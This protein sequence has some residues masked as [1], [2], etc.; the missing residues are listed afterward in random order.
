MNAS[1][2]VQAALSKE[3]LKQLISAKDASVT[4]SKQNEKDHTSKVWS[5]FSTIFVNNIK[6][7]YVLCESCMLL[8]AYKHATGTGGMQKHIGSCSQKSSSMDELNKK[9][10]R[11][12]STQ[13]KIN[14]IMFHLN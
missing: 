3:N 7:D 10:L 12:T 14:S 4:F 1:G 13:Q 11:H 6:Q 5:H 2:A 9:K 8:I